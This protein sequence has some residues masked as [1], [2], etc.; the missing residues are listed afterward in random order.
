[1]VNT[2]AHLLIRQ[3]GAPGVEPLEDMIHASV[4]FRVQLLNDKGSENTVLQP[5]AILFI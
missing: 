4:V 3:E 1:M 2:V 5:S